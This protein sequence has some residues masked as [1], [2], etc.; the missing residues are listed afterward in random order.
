MIIQE[1]DVVQGIRVCLI[2][3]VHQAMGQW[4]KDQDAAVLCRRYQSRAIR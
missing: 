4:I 1:P 3:L 2:V